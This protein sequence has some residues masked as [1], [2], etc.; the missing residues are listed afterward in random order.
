[1]A[2]PSNEFDIEVP[3]KLHLKWFIFDKFTGLNTKDDPEKIAD[4]QNSGGYNTSVNNG[5]RIS[6]RHLGYELF[7]DLSAYGNSVNRSH[8]FKK[9]N[10]DHVLMAFIDKYLLY[11]NKISKTNEILMSVLTPGQKQGIC[12]FNDSAGQQSWTYFTNQVDGMQRWNGAYATIASATATTLTLTPTALGAAWYL[13]GFSFAPATM[14]DT[15]T[16]FTITQISGTTYRYTWT[17]VGTSPLLTSTKFPIGT[18]IF[19]SAT[20]FSSHN[21][22]TFVVTGL[23]TDYFEVAN[24]N[25]GGGLAENNKAITGGSIKYDYDYTGGNSVTI[26]GTSYVYTGGA[27]GNVL[28]GVSTLPALTAGTAVAQ[29]VAASTNPLSIT[30]NSG[31]GTTG[32]GNKLFSMFGRLFVYGVKGLEQSIYASEVNNASNFTIPGSPVATSPLV[33]VLGEGGGSVTDI[34]S[35]EQGMYIAKNSIVYTQTSDFTVPPAPLKPF[36]N[37]SQTMGVLEGT[38]FTSNNAVFFVTPDGQIMSL[39]RLSNINYPQAVPISDIIKPTF[40][41]SLNDSA[42]GVVYKNIAYLATKN[43]VNSTFNDK[44]YVWDIQN[45]I[46]DNPISGW[47]VNDWVI[48]KN[49]N[50]EQLYWSDSTSPTIWLVNENSVDAVN[51]TAGQFNV[52]SLWLSKQFTFGQPQCLK[53]CEGFFIEG[54]TYSNSNFGIMLLSDDNGFTQMLST[55]FLGVETSYQFDVATT[56]EYPFGEN[57]FGENPFSGTSPSI[58]KIKFRIYLNEFVKM[59]NFYNLQLALYSSDQNDLWE[60]TTFGFLISTASEETRKSLTRKFN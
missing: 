3:K 18:Y 16:V 32:F 7:A 28:T 49:S 13:N 55:T 4:G 34:S 27:Y 30:A 38:F 59:K 24:T 31:S 56:T 11:Y 48:Y 8:A 40:S 37:K 42:N 1:M 25:V 47:T 60:V 51:G 43:T 9:M 33:I 21:Q 14:G 35:D 54:Y 20:G 39:Q 26:G 58:N 23:G 44:V 12:D 52:N 45:S 5:D 17:G 19:I 53:D 22:G 15:T 50:I 57:P 46:W 41:L 6:V 29:S 10:G 36:D 2:K